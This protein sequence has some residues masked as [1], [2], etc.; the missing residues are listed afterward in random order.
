MAR[1]RSIPKIRPLARYP[2]RVVKLLGAVSVALIALAG[3]VTVPGEPEPESAEVT[4]APPP[5]EPVVVEPEAPGFDLE[6]YSIDEADSVWVV[7]NKLRPLN[8]IDY[9]PADL[10]APNV[11]SAFDPLMRKEASDALEKMYAEA[12]EAG[13]PFRIQSS[14]RSYTT[15]LRVKANSVSRLGQEVSDQRSARAGH[16]EHQTGLAVDLTTPSGRC[17]LEACFADTPEGVWV[18]E[19]AWRFGFIVR[20]VEGKSDIHGYV[21]E[22]WHFRYVGL[23]L[24][25]EI[26]L[27]GYPTL[28]ELF[29]LDPAPNYAGPPD[30]PTPPAPS[31]KAPSEPDSGGVA[32]ADPGTSPGRDEVGEPDFPDDPE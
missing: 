11:P 30:N 5:P 4:P 19:N 13:V 16:S 21:F 24:A 31:D 3:C 29:G 9:A 8:P 2:Q 25:E 17:T 14:Y 26:H 27:Q 32:P 15:Q 20:Y 18:A 7:V 23:E 6:M 1:A 22:P 28:E 12:V 10:V